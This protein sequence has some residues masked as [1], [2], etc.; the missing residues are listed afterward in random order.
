MGIQNSILQEQTYTNEIGKTPSTVGTESYV[1][2]LLS[3]LQMIAKLGGL[4]ALSDD[5][6][7]VLSKHM[8]GPIAA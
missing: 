4:T 1:T 3:E 7:T 5:I 6:D 2:D 8:A